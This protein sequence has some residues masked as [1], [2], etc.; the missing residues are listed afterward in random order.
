[1]THLSPTPS[2]LK[3]LRSRAI[4][5]GIDYDKYPPLLRV[6]AIVRPAR[7]SDRPPGLLPISA[8]TWFTWVAEGLVPQPTRF[9]NG[10]SAWRLVDVIRIALDGV[11]RPAGHGRKLAPT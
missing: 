8:R 9:E 4:A 6:D 5:A 3:A 2:S 11:K 7:G 10:V 1:V